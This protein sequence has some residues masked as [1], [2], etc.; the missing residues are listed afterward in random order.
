[1]RRGTTVRLR[2]CALFAFLEQVCND[3][4]PSG[5]YLRLSPSG[6]KTWVVHQMGGDWCT[7]AAKCLD[8]RTNS[9]RLTS[10]KTW[11]GTP[12]VP[13]AVVTVASCVAT[14]PLPGAISMKPSIR[15]VP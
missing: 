4:T 5:M 2:F 10:S 13:V 6:S 8:R 9:P 15:I 12:T 3:G 11:P 1:M 7:D 14:P